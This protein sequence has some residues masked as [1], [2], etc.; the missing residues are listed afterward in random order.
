MKFENVRVL[1][2]ALAPRLEQIGYFLLS[3]SQ[4]RH[5]S[6]VIRTNCMNCFDR[7]NV[8]QAAF[9]AKVL[10]AQLSEQGTSIDLKT[11]LSTQ[12]FNSLWADNSDAISRQYT[13]TTALKKNY[14]WT[15]K[16]NYL[17]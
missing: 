13:S 6:G 2:K 1:M 15:Q 17:S 11:S 7:T 4:E 8:M 5:Q 12:C 10:E 14:T 16:H 3:P 9:K